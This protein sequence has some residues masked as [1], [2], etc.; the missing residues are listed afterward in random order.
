MLG[1]ARRTLRQRLSLQLPMFAAFEQLLMSIA[2]R[3]AAA[4]AERTDAP[5]FGQGQDNTRDVVMALPP[6][7]EELDATC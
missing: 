2:A 5:V 7:N 6:R 1:S 4:H 3:A